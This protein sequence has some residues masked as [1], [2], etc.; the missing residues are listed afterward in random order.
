MP[1]LPQ[2]RVFRADQSRV[3]LPAPGPESED[4]AVIQHVGGERRGTNARRF[5][6]PVPGDD[7]PDADGLLVNGK[8]SIEEVQVDFYGPHAL[9]R[10]QALAML[11]WSMEGVNFFRAYGLS[12]CYSREPINN[13]GLTGPG[14]G[15][16]GQYISRYTVRVFF[17]VPT[18]VGIRQPWF[19]KAILDSIRP[20]P[21][22]GAAAVNPAAGSAA[23]SGT[24]PQ[25][26]AGEK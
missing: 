21:D 23:G 16:P 22:P 26:Q 25:N 20:V 7:N 18:S 4:Y 1:T 10:A 11:S 6:S 15:G 12:S 9:A 3:S 17:S 14:R 5:V 19:D 24:D 2:E 8:L 13:T